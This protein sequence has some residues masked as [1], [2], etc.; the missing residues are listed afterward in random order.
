MYQRKTIQLYWIQWGRSLKY[1]FCKE[2]FSQSCIS[3]KDEHTHTDD[4]PIKCKFCHK[5]F[6]NYEYP[7]I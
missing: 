4:K 1:Q 3:N 7:V 6:T 5:G 2:G